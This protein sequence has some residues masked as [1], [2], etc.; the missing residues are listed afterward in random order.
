MLYNVKNPQVPIP[1]YWDEFGPFYSA[2]IGLN[3]TCGQNYTYFQNNTFHSFK[4]MGDETLYQELHTHTYAQTH[5]YTFDI[6]Q[7]KNVI[8]A[9][10]YSKGILQSYLHILS[11]NE[12]LSRPHFLLSAKAAQSSPT[13]HC[14]SLLSVPGSM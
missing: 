8:I 4:P 12:S 13:M 5:T 7:L 11:F 14:Q 3:H 6:Y 9:L 1:H 10:I 2:K